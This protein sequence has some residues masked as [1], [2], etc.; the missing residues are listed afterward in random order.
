M[1]CY[2]TPDQLKRRLGVVYEAI[3]ESDED[4]VSDLDDARAEIDGCI[5]KRYRVPVTAETAVALL[6]G[7]NLTLAEE[8]AYSRTA[9]SEYAEKVSSRV[10]RVRK[11]LEMILAGTFQ[12]AGAEENPDAPGAGMTLV[13][14]SEP[15][16][17]REL[18]KGF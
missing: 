17:T 13:Q 8:R 18:M 5:V 4:A 10:A 11:Y 14:V 9:G 12:L 16:F 3:Y 1:S 6:Q 2:A 7:W 15:V